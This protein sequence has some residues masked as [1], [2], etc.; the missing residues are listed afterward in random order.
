MDGRG[1]YVER[2]G[3]EWNVVGSHSVRLGIIEW[4]GP[5]TGSNGCR[6]RASQPTRSTISTC[7]ATL[8]ASP[9][10]PGNSG[11]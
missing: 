6:S 5:F 8:R 1:S 11:P 3:A 9:D 10:A 7:L 2:T 4:A